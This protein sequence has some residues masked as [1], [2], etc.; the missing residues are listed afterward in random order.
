VHSDGLP[1]DTHELQARVQRFMQRVVT[2]PQRVMSY[3]QHLCAC[4]AAATQFMRMLSAGVILRR[5]P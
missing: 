2:V 5:R 3:F 4:Y 1:H